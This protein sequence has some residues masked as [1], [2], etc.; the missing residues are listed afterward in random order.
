M[1]Y[2]DKRDAFL[3]H[4]KNVS[5]V[6]PE[7]I[8]IQ[9]NEYVILF[10][11]LNM[12]DAK[13]VDALIRQSQIEDFGFI[14]IFDFPLSENIQNNLLLYRL[15]KDRQDILNPIVVPLL[16]RFDEYVPLSIEVVDNK[17]QVDVYPYMLGKQ[18]NV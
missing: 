7:L 17:V 12:Y 6:N 2:R 10:D 8:D 3:A 9:G 5:I 14:I 13:E 18:N 15:F 4:T 16:S 1:S 11:N